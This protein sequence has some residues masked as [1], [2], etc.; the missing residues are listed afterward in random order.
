[1]TEHGETA[2]NGPASLVIPAAGLGTRMRIVDPAVPK[3][4]LPV[5]YKPAVQ[6]ALEEGLSA[7][8]KKIIVVI[9]RQKEIIRRYFEDKKFAEKMFPRAVGEVE[10]INREC[11]VIFRYQEK[12]LGEADAISYARDIAGGHAVAVIYPDNLYVPAPGALKVLRRVYDSHK[13]DVIALVQTGSGDTSGTGNSGR[14]DTELI[15][16]SLFRIKRFHPKGEGHFI[17]RFKGELRACG[18]YISG[19]YLF[20][21]IERLRAS[22]KEKEFTD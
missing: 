14:V 18:I 5:G 21:Y 17:P 22:V 1:M 3:E 4:M 12:P 13:K 11:S 6:Y 10:T 16:G 15:D 20:D 2:D 19:P 8:I 9:S 7:G